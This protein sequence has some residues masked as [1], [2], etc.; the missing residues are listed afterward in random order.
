MDKGGK[1]CHIYVRGS[2]SELYN[3]RSVK[4]R[5]KKEWIKEEKYVTFMSWGLAVNFI[6]SGQ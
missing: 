3:L 1:I 5:L 2:R 6:T 4:G